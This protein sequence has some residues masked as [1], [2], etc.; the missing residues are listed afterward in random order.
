MEMPPSVD[1]RVLPWIPTG[2][3]QA[4]AKQ[5][6]DHGRER[7]WQSKGMKQACSPM[8]EVGP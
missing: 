5:G 4:R 7:I 8:G 3:Q 6:G 2:C 1:V